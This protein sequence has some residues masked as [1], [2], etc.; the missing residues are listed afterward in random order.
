MPITDA[1]MGPTLAVSDLARSRA[2]Y[3]EK[4]GWEP[5]FE[6]PELVLY[7]VGDSRFSLYTTPSAGTAKNTVMTWNVGDVDADLSRLRGNGLDFEEYDFG[8]VRTV[9]GVMTDPSGHKNAWFQDPDGNIV[10]LLSGPGGIPGMSAGSITAMLA[11]SDI[12]RAKD[13][14]ASKLGYEP[15]YENPGAVLTYTS[16][17][18]SFTVY[19]TSFAGT[20][21]N[22][23]A[24]WRMQGIRDEVARLRD[25]GVV[26]GDFDFGDGDRTV[27][28]ILSDQ[29]GD[30]NAWFQDSEGN[31]LS[32][33][34]DRGDIPM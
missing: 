8:E 25:R 22:T 12:A 30:V 14:Y 33:A 1:P 13:W 18:S 26:F 28:G 9:D 7:R 3:A 34:E 29:D 23:V 19:A 27:D 32:L 31:W 24:V 16:G 20:A 2:W 15:V 4:L 6:L 21:K 5:F 10:G 11:A 17:G